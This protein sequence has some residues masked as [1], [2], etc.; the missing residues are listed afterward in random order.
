[1]ILFQMDLDMC[2]L[3]LFELGSTRSNHE[4]EKS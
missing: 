4:A 3:A 1:M 2:F